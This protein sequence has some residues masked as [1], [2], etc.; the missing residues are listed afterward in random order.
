MWLESACGSAVHAG[1][2]GAQ[3]HY[4]TRDF[5]AYHY[6]PIVK[7]TGPLR[8]EGRLLSF[9]LKTAYAE[10]EVTDST[11]K[12]CASAISLLLQ[13]GTSAFEN[14]ISRK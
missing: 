1:L 10:A 11:G 3:V 4:S 14:K 5:K 8:V 2:L 13:R 6:S 7:D 12:I 9:G